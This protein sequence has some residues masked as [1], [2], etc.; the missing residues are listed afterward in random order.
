MGSETEAARLTPA[1]SGPIAYLPAGVWP[2][3]PS[4]PA[5]TAGYFDRLTGAFTASL[6]AARPDRVNLMAIILH[7]E[8]FTHIDRQLDLLEDWI[9]RHVVAWSERGRLV[10]ATYRDVYEVWVGN[11]PAS[12]R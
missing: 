6:A 1:T 11:R 4:G 2:P 10:G 9:R 7:P 8:E 5:F 12:G 3:G